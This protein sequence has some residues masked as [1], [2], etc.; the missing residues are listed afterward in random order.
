MSKNDNWT[1]GLIDSAWFGSDYEGKNGRERQSASV[2]KVS[3]SSSAS[4]RGGCRKP[5]A[6]V[7]SLR[8]RARACRSCRWSAPAWAARP[9]ASIALEVP[10]FATVLQ[11]GRSVLSGTAAALAEDPQVQKAYLGTH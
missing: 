11:V 1:L 8:I 2:S 10:D 4:I 6:N 7:M 9:T 3:V 5:T